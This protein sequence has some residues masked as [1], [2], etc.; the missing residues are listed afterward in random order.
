MP[1]ALLLQ[2]VVSALK[3]GGEVMEP[4]G[5]MALLEE[6]LVDRARGAFVVHWFGVAVPLHGLSLRVVID[7]FEALRAR[8]TEALRQVP[9]SSG[10][11]MNL[12]EPL[13]GM[14]GSMAGM[15]FT[16]TGFLMLSVAVSK[17][18]PQWFAQLGAGINWLTM[19]MIALLPAAI[20]TVAFPLVVV[21]VI[22]G[23]LVR[24]DDLAPG[25]NLLGAVA[26]LL[27]A[28]GTFLKTLTA[29]RA[30]V[31]NPLLRGILQVAD[32]LATL[33]PQLLGLIAVVVVHIG[34]RLLPLANQFKAFGPVLTESKDLLLFIVEDWLA[35][36]TKV[37]AG[38][39][40][41]FSVLTHVTDLLQTVLPKGIKGVTEF[42][43]TVVANL[44]TVTDETSIELDAW[45]KKAEPQLG[46]FFKNLPP[47][48]IISALIDTLT[49]AIPLLKLPPSSPAWYDFAL[50]PLIKK[51]KK[52][53]TPPPLAAFPATPSL[54]D[55]A[56]ME[57]AAG[58]RPRFALSGAGIDE[59][60]KQLEAAPASLFTLSDETLTAMK[61]AQHPPSAFAPQ[62]ERL[63]EEAKAATLEDALAAYRA[64]EIPYRDRLA[65][66]IQNVLPD[67][68]HEYVAKLESLFLTL[69]EKLY[70][71]KERYAAPS[72]PVR[73]LPDTEVLRVEVDEFR[74]RATATGDA[75]V[76][77][78]GERLR[79]RLLTQPYRVG[80]D[81]GSQ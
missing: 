30:E 35:G 67:Q 80:A 63:A 72:F 51:I 25:Y 65:Q 44:R 55:T 26:D 81:Q 37:Y 5:Q 17:M 3:K 77:A 14:A 19:G 11:G 70:Q 15:L 47:I 29:P 1:I 69:D 64:A 6:L 78:W 62:K 54:P 33:F 34:P 57:R 36:L 18:M 49:V 50:D 46:T 66:I 60:R 10:S 22:F 32:K 16:P 52:E 38:K 13:A 79:E 23:L 21:A 9:T 42:L 71:S 31:A 48:R 2:E 41:P 68:A 40:G 73:A 53:F 27:D 39:N 74:I 8:Y 61:R 56:L 45:W 43:E 76:R 24:Q 7:N 59:L 4:W 12:T 28:A 58:G 75:P 20:V